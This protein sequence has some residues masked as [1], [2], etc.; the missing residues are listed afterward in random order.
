MR[1]LSE[2]CKLLKITAVKDIDSSDN[3]RGHVWLDHECTL[4]AASA[5]YFLTG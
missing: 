2:D 1:L 3:C 4:K 5:V